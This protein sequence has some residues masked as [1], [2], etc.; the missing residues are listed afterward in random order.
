M[1]LLGV[2]CAAMLTSF[3]ALRFAPPFPD[4]A[5]PIAAMSRQ[6]VPTLALLA[7]FG[8]PPWMPVVAL[9]AIAWALFANQHDQRADFRF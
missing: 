9:V 8:V 5:G 4:L 7:S 2:F 3:S 1:A 6:I